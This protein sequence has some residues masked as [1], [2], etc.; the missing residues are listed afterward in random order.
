MTESD[1]A[2]DSVMQRFE[3]SAR[4]VGAAEGTLERP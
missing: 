3:D 4:G 1:R 2:L